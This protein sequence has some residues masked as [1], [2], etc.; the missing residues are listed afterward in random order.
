MISLDFGLRRLLDFVGQA[1]CG[2]QRV[3]QVGLA[4]AVLVEERFLAHQVLAQPIDL[5]QR[6]LVVVGGLGQEGDDFGLSKPRSWVRKRCCLRSS[7][8]I[9]MTRSAGD[10]PA[11][12]AEVLGGGFVRSNINLSLWSCS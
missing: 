7:G 2:Q 12:A 4:L 9:R 1:L 11:F 3:A 8:A 10:D 6:V 5:A